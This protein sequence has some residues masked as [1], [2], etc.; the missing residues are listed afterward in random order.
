MIFFPGIMSEKEIET[1]YKR[2]AQMMHPDKGG[3]TELFQELVKQKD[4]ALKL[5]KNPNVKK[6]VKMKKDFQNGKVKMV[7]SRKVTGNNTTIHVT[8]IKLEPK[9]ALS[10]LREFRNF[11]N[12]LL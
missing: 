2:L 5:A 7:R 6:I 8:Q 11:F 3:N 12:D 10:A 9:E 4:A 1:E